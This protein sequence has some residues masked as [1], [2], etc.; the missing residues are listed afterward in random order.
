MVY[1]LHEL[2]L[3]LE[4]L[5]RSHCMTL[6]S[7]PSGIQSP[8]VGVWARNSLV[9]SLPRTSGIQS[10][11]LVSSSW[12]R[13]QCVS[14]MA[15][16]ASVPSPTCL[17]TQHCLASSWAGDPYVIMVSSEEL[18]RQII[19]EK[20]NISNY[21]RRAAAAVASVVSDSVWPHK[22]QPIGLL[23]PWDSPGKNTGVGCHFLLQC[24]KVK[25]QS[26]VGQPCLTLSDPMDCRLP[27]FSI[28]GIFQS[29]VLEWGAIAFFVQQS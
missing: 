26:E 14:S 2:S 22:R 6:T 3:L 15:K 23:C 5:P 11:G 7:F 4:T 24:M 18:E 10:S 17:R 20:E 25:S 19:T 28:H 29:R 1:K 13:K 21:S 8:L 27:G 12:K 9:C 16:K